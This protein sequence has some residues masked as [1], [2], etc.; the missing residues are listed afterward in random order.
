MSDAGSSGADISAD[1]QTALSDL[2]LRFGLSFDSCLI[3]DIYSSV[4][5]AIQSEAVCPGICVFW[6]LT[7][8][9]EHV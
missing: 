6:R 4:C 2:G 1:T 3:A 5:A 8:P 9:P 7:H